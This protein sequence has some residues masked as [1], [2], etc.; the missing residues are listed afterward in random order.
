MRSILLALTVVLV[1][2]AFFITEVAAAFLR[3]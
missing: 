3:T 1:A 2:S